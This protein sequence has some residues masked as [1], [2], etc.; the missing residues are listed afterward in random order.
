MKVKVKVKVEV[1]MN[2]EVMLK[3]EVDDGGYGCCEEKNRKSKK[4]TACLKCATWAPFKPF[5]FANR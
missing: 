1:K 5:W 3:V 4:D 2:V